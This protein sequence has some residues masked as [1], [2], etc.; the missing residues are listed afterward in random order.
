MTD[1]AQ[2]FLNESRRYLRDVYPASIDRAVSALT[3]EQIWW[4]PNEYS[5]SIGN[6]ILHLSGNVRQ[7][8]VAGVGGQP[9]ERNRQQEFDERRTLPKDELVARLMT[10]LA[11]ADA[12]LVNLQESELSEARQIHGSDTTVMKAV[13]HVVEHFAMHT[14]QIQWITKSQLGRQ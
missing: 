7:W 3:D 12:V 2:T 10:V 14:G 6:L 1:A 4:R 8:I 9:N 13:Y 11:E 5:N